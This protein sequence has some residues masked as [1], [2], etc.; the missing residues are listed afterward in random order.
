M[1]T[2]PWGRLGRRGSPDGAREDG[3]YAR[4]RSRR[5]WLWGLSA[6]TTLAMTI[7]AVASALVANPSDDVPEDP[8]VVVVLGG[9]GQERADLGIE[10][11]ERFGSPLLLSSSAAHFGAERGY[12]CGVE[13][14]CLQPEPETTTGEA[15]DVARL[16]VQRGWERATVVTSSFHTTRAR[17]LFRQCLDSVSVVGAQ[18]RDGGPEL[19]DYVR[20][21]VGTLAALSIRRAC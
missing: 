17:I 1:A 2:W 12:R 3:A 7:V 16:M 6:V 19:A 13:A 14:I 8:D 4:D 20:E 11:A 15:Q 21:V 18:R 5:P 9:F 10:L